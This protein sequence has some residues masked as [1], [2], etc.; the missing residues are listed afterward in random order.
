MGK[1]LLRTL[2]LLALGL[3]GIGLWA[4]GPILAQGRI[5]AAFIARTTCSCVFVAGRSLASC[6][7]DWPSGAETIA[8]RQEDDAVVASA[9]LGLVSARA[10]F[11]Q[12]YGCSF[13]EGFA[14]AR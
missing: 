12:D 9:A 2:G 11:E 1:H 10:V 6:R 3:V 14:R 4:S 7:T 5:G 8:V 13:P